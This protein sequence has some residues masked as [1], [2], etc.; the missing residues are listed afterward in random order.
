MQFGNIC[1]GGVEI[2]FSQISASTGRSGTEL[3]QFFDAHTSFSNVSAPSFTQTHW[4]YYRWDVST[5]VKILIFLQNLIPKQIANI[6]PGVVSGV[7]VAN[8]EISNILREYIP[9][10]FDG[11]LDFVT[12]PFP[13]PLFRTQT[14]RWLIRVAKTIF[15]KWT[16]K[17]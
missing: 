8:P 4:F 9:R 1:W 2:L 12:F 7:D 10:F 6:V 14:V 5:Y 15:K 16:K 17:K 13:L 3:Q 11:A